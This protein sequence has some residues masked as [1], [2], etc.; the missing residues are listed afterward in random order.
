MWKKIIDFLLM[1]DLDWLQV[2]ITTFCNAACLYC[3]R[4]VYGSRWQNRHIDPA[5]FEKIGPAL[6]RTGLAHLQGWGEPLLH[7]DFFRL[8]GL[9]KK[10]G[11][12]VGTTTNGIL[13]DDEKAR[14]IA[15]S[16]LDLISFSLAGTGPRND[17]ARRGTSL[18]G[19]LRAIESVAGARERSGTGRPA[20]HVSYLLLKSGLDD[21]ARLP[22]LLAGSG[23]TEAVVSTLDFVPDES[24][25]AEAFP[26]S[27]KRGLAAARSLIREV[28]REG[29]KRGLV[30]HHRLP[31]DRILGRPCAENPLRAAFISAGGL[32]SACVFGC[33]P[34]K[35]R[36][37]EGEPGSPAGRGTTFGNLGDLSFS[38]VWRR[39]DYRSFRRKL[40]AG[41]PDQ[42]CRT[43]PKLSGR[44]W[45]RFPFY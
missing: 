38:A 21:L 26:P 4:T 23:A 45:T 30:I 34:A 9:A 15:A 6:K 17:A 36:Q 12:L 39:R 13:M 19:V 2:E 20:V 29:E 24:L 10:S 11:C 32:V 37:I 44:T 31:G 1:P 5:V 14:Q 41:R 33:L 42:P 7:P 27:D 18:A 43:C 3:P 8:V 25:A 22:E 16:G 40:E 35:D 28:T